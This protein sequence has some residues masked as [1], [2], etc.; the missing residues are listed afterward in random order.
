MMCTVFCVFYAFS[1]FIKGKI[2]WYG[3]AL[4]L[5]WSYSLH[6]SDWPQTVR[7]IES[8]LDNYAHPAQAARG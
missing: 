4:S 1:S 2:F 5:F 7:V 3:V 6:S 8:A